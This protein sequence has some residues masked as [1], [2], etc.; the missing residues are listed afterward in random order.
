TEDAT[1]HALH[2]SSLPSSV[3]WI[4][5]DRC[6]HLFTD[7]Y[8]DKDALRAL[9]SKASTAPLSALEVEERR[10]HS[11]KIVDRVS[12]IRGSIEGRWLDVG[13]GRGSLMTTAAEFGYDAVGVDLLAARTEPLVEMG[14]DARSIAFEDFED[15]TGFDVISLDGTLAHMPFPRRAL[16][17]ALKMM[18]PGG[19]IFISTPNVDTHAWKRM[20]AE[21]QNPYWSDLEHC[22]NF[23][24]GHLYWLLGQMGFQPCHYMASS[25]TP[26]GMEVCAWR[27]EDLDAQS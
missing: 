27:S 4:G 9:L 12:Q 26:A 6:G 21:A 24:R 17:H 13:T 22:H 11:A 7:G 18:R 3:A 5:C 15:A 23:S 19:V 2:Q 25:E 8:F 1:H 14:Y 20:D 10:A 16:A